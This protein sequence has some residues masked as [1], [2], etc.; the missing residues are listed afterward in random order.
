MTLW[1]LHFFNFDLIFQTQSWWGEKLKITSAST[2]DCGRHDTSHDH[3]LLQTPIQ[4]QQVCHKQLALEESWQVNLR[5]MDSNYTHP[6]FAPNYGTRFLHQTMASPFCTKL[7][8]P[9]SAPNYGIPFLHQTIRILM[10][11]DDWLNDWCALLAT[12]SSFFRK[13]ILL[14]EFN[15]LSYWGLVLRTWIG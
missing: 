6:L 2:R 9:L 5:G 14:V 4:V 15:F 7:W 1:L 3:G 12:F 13:T 11:L 8:H 10:L